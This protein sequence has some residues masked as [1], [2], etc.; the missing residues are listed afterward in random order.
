MSQYV[1]FGPNVLFENLKTFRLEVRESFII[2]FES[3]RVVI[4]N[5]I[6]LKSFLPHK[7]TLLGLADWLE[8]GPKIVDFQNSVVD[9]YHPTCNVW[10]ECPL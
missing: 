3:I 6:F 1:V 7:R 5:I 9:F 10:V 2:V 8:V 4:R